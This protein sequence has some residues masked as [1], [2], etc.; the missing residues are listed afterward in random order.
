M[1]EQY[2]DFFEKCC[3]Q[4]LN[5]WLKAEGAP[6]RSEQ[7]RV[8]SMAYLDQSCLDLASKRVLLTSA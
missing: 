3:E 8:Q 6:G 4:R 5:G 7:E 2:Q 1:K